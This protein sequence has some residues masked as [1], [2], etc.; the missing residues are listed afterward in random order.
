VIGNPSIIGSWKF[1]PESKAL[2]ARAEDM[3]L[4]FQFP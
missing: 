2:P 3:D 4:L 1:V